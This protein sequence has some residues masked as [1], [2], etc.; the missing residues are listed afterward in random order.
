METSRTSVSMA[1]AVLPGTLF[2][3]HRTMASRLHFSQSSASGYLFPATPGNCSEKQQLVQPFVQLV[4][5][6]LAACP[7][8]RLL[9]CVLMFGAVDPKGKI[10]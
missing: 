8:F 4:P 7:H 1:Q 6:A 5:A 2:Q 10:D 3:E 9:H